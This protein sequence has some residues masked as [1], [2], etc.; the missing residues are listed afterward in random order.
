MTLY[1]DIEQAAARHHLA[2]FGGLHDDGDTLLLLGPAE[3]GFWAHF[4]ASP[5]Y[6]DAQPDPLDRWSKRVIGALATVHGAAAI[7]PS[8]GPP[9]PPFISWALA[10]GRAWRS[11]V[12][13]LVHDT[14]GLFA[15]FRGA[16]RLHGTM[17]LPET[18]GS[19]CETCTDQ[20][21]RTACPLDALQADSY[22]VPTCTSHIRTSDLANCTHSG[23]AARRACPV[24]Q[25]YGRLPA[26]SA[27]HM[28]AFI[29]D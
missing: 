21:C 10:T 4:T 29:G 15:S 23:C 24:S 20:P 18:S 1:S 28:R 3:P 13:L 27:F 12:G 14:A 7:F 26:Q 9:Y 16:L 22:D 19:P 17:S 11:P 6:S 2:I 5:E 25:S 8:D